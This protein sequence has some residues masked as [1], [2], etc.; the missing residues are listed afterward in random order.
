MVDVSSVLWM[1]TQE[2]KKVPAMYLLI[3]K[4][5]YWYAMRCNFMGFS[6]LLLFDVVLERRKPID[7]SMK[8]A[9]TSLQLMNLQDWKV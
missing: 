7:K 8:L 4:M 9:K 2:V 6:R 1:Y 5:N 3:K